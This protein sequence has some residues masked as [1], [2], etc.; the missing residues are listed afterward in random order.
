MARAGGAPPITKRVA[1]SVSNLAKVRTNLR[2]VP[3]SQ[4]NERGGRQRELAS[5]S[6]LASGQ[7]RPPDAE[8]GEKCGLGP[9]GAEDVISA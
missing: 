8:R 5:A 7:K 4:E 3:P 6:C 9:S 1:G 2:K